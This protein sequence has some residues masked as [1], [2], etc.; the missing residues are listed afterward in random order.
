MR[1]K[2]N[3]HIVFFDEHAELC[4][5]S[6]AQTKDLAKYR[7]ARAAIV[8]HLRHN[9]QHTHPALRVKRFSSVRA[10]AFERYLEASGVYFILCHDGAQTSHKSTQAARPGDRGSAEDGSATKNE[11]NRLKRIVARGM[12][13]WF[14][15]R[16]YNVASIDGLEWRDTKVRPRIGDTSSE[17]GLD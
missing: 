3:F 13:Y 7:L 8:R 10:A 2:C 4:I 9:I 12:I 1:R 16:E 6:H 11:N 14:L 5:P 15:T 17:L